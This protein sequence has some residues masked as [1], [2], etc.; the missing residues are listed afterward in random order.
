MLIVVRWNTT[1]AHPELCF[2]SFDGD[3]GRLIDKRIGFYSATEVIGNKQL[4]RPQRVKE[5]LKRGKR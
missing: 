5:Y 3:N 4:A 1:K 2:D